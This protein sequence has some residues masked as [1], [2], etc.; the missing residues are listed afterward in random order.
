MKKI[1]KE[2][3]KENMDRGERFKLID[4]RDTPEYEREHIVGAIH[5]LISE[6]RPDRLKKL[7]DED[8]LIVTYSED[9]NC[10]AK[11]IAAQTLTDLGYSHVFAYDGSWKEWKESGY[12]VE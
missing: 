12:P 5:L 2:E 10:P 3:I 1:T 4:V 6:M 7:V 9:I 8:E 11:M